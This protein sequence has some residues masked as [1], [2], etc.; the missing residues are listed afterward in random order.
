VE[1]HT[2]RRALA[3]ISVFAISVCLPGSAAAYF[4]SLG[5]VD[6]LVIH[7]ASGDGVFVVGEFIDG[8]GDTLAFRWNTTGADPLEEIGELPTGGVGS[9]AYRA[10]GNGSVAVGSSRVVDPNDPLLD[11]DEA[12]LWVESGGMAGLGFLEVSLPAYASRATAVSADGLVAVGY[13]TVT[14]PNNPT[15]TVLE[16]FVWEDSVMTGLGFLADDGNDYE[17]QALAISADRKTVVGK[18][19]NTDPM[20]PWKSVD[21]AFVWSKG[22]LKGLGFLETDTQK[23]RSEATAV[24]SDG[25]WVAGTSNVVDPKNSMLSTPQAFR[26]SKDTGMEPLGFLPAGPSGQ[27]ESRVTAISPNGLLVVGDSRSAGGDEAFI[28]TAADGMRSL[29]DTLESELGVDLTGWQLGA[30]MGISGNGQTLYG[31]ATNPSGQTE[32]Y[33]AVVPEPRGGF[34]AGVGFLIWAARRRNRV[35]ER[36]R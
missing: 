17:S 9:S 26:W 4:S 5:A 20:K 12:F 7:G 10:S 27:V 15:V 29:K 8:S 25:V 24:S 19:M 31:V 35:P 2:I 3:L 30:P 11:V 13:S 32:A 33:V 6:G 18:A 16:G 1:V 14:D 22:T 36:L 23:V 28:W 21:E 34:M